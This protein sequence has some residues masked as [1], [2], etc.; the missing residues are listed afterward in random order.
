M[1]DPELVL[2]DEPSLG[3]RSLLVETIFQVI[4]DIRKA[5]KTPLL[6]EQNAHKGAFHRRPR[7][8]GA[9]ADREIG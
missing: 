6:V 1:S 3:L 2:L 5:G 4:E 7:F 8:T 9:G